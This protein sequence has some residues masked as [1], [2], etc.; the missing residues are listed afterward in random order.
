M[1]ISDVI[2]CMLQGTQCDTGIP[3]TFYGENICSVCERRQ[4]TLQLLAAV[5]EKLVVIP[6]KER[7]EQGLDS[8]ESLLAELLS[9][10]FEFDFR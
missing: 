4:P 7:S 1:G 6:Q 9:M 2:T 8:C 10:C 3:Y 5:N